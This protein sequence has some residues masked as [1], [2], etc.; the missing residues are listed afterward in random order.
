MALTLTSLRKDNGSEMT[1]GKGKGPPAA[2]NDPLEGPRASKKP[3][4]NAAAQAL[5]ALRWKDTTAA[6]RTE[7]A[8]RIAKLGWKG[9][10]AKVRIK[11]G[12][13][14]RS[15]DRCPCG[16]MTR[17]RAKKRNHQCVAPPS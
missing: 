14:P 10:A 9:R 4:K 8:R 13:R 15:Q 2:E 7:F 5:S 6:E 17:E 1:A 11:A 3:K 16:A 12:G